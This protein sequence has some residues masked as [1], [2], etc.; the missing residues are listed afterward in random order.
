MKLDDLLPQVSEGGSGDDVSLSAFICTDMPLAK[1][2]QALE[3]VYEQTKA[4]KDVVTQCDDML[5]KANDAKNGY[6]KIIKEKESEIFEL[7]EKLTHLRTDIEESREVYARKQSEIDDL[8]QKK[9]KVAEQLDKVTKYK[10][11]AMMFW[12]EKYRELNLHFV[13][14]DEVGPETKITEDNYIGTDD[15]TVLKES[16]QVNAE[17]HAAEVLL[18]CT[19]GEP[20]KEQYVNLVKTVSEGEPGEINYK[21][22]NFD[23]LIN[24]YKT[25]AASGNEG[26]LNG[27]GN[28]D[29]KKGWSIFKRGTKK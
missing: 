2:K 10:E 21:D 24:I 16:D 11:S 6:E 29:N 17:K 14:D 28:V 8:L 4:C 3:Q 5:E 27:A 1:P 7:E 25:L 23:E 19:G 20:M 9:D 26:N 12:R 15:D 18:A 13:S 22:L